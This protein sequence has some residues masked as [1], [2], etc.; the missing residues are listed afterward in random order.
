[1]AVMAKQEELDHV[2]HDQPIPLFYVVQDP[3]PGDVLS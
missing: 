3:S 1:M 2:V